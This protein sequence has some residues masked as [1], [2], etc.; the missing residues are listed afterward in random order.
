MYTKFTDSTLNEYN[1]RINE[2]GFAALRSKFNED[3]SI[4]DYNLDSTFTN[5]EKNL[6]TAEYDD[7]QLTINDVLNFLNFDRSYSQSLITDELIKTTIHEACV[8]LVL[9]KKATDMKIDDDVQY[10]KIIEDYENGLL[11]FKIEQDELWKKVKVSDT[12]IKQYYDSNKKKFTQTDKKGNIKT[13]SFSEAKPEVAN[14]LQQL[15]YK[16]IEKEYLESLKQKYTVHINEDVL[17]EA[18]NN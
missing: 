11:V 17:L 18:F 4:K 13:K 12:A 14:E 9:Y 3:K 15:K 8:P 10:R 6:V 2:D 7:G 1:Y 16:E 5:E